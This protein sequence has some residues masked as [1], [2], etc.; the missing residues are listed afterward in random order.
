MKEKAENLFLRKKGE[1]MK[2]NKCMFIYI[3][4]Y[5]YIP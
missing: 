2:N 5:G 1:I 3:A 4:Y